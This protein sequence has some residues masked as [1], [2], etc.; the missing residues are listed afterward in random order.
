MPSRFV[1]SVQSFLKDS[2]FVPGPLDG[3][4]GSQ[5]VAAW[6]L[7]LDREEV[8]ADPPSPV[9]PVLSTGEIVPE[10]E[11]IVTGIATV[12]GLNYNGSRDEGDNG[13]GAWGVKTANTSILGVS[14]PEAVL[15]L[16]FGLSGTWRQEAVSV[17]RFLTLHNV[18]VHVTRAGKTVVAPVVDAGPAR[19]YKGKLLHNA[20][21]L[22][23]AVAHALE[24]NGEA[25]VS[26]QIVSDGVALPIKGWDR[27]NGCEVALTGVA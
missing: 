13:E 23:Y 24:T 7:F 26:Y 21:D 6:N 20:I 11:T 18:L 12:F 4:I 15:I 1:Q 27:V 14:L 3:V 19:T 16:T 9:K 22:T 5:T 10:S 8:K 17:G 25:I 2:G